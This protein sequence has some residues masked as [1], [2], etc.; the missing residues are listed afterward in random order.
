[1][2]PAPDYTLKTD[3]QTLLSCL[4]GER[5]SFSTPQL[6]NIFTTKTQRAQSKTNDE[7]IFSVSG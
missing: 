2:F 4:W 7:P 6:K 3:I 5:F 1:M